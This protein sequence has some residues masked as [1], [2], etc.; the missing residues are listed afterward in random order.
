MPAQIKSAVVTFFAAIFT[1]TLLFGIQFRPVRAADVS[2][3]IAFDQYVATIGRTPRLAISISNLGPNPIRTTRFECI[4]Q[5]TS[6]SASSISQRPAVIAA[7]S[8]FTTEQYYR[9]AS[10]GIT[11]VHCELDATDMVTGETINI[12]TPTQTV[13]VLSETRLYFNAYSAT[14]VATV[15]Q[16]VYLTALYGNRGQTPF[17]NISISCPQ[18]G[19]SLE[20][21][22]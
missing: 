3:S 17:T 1:L 6:L 5:G 14:R 8:T 13:E 7:N 15:G 19:R 10:P 11:Q 20:F 18:L 2:V 4:K 16:T 21:I 12:V 22:S 9:A